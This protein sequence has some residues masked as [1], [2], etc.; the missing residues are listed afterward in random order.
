MN[1]TPVQSIGLP[2]PI[3][4]INREEI[5]VKDPDWHGTLYASNSATRDKW[6][7]AAKMTGTCLGSRY[8][9][10]PVFG[11]DNRCKKHLGPLTMIFVESCE[12]PTAA[13]IQSMLSQMQKASYKNKSSG[14][15]ILS[16][17]TLKG[18]SL[19]ASHKIPSVHHRYCGFVLFG[20]V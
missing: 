12:Q 20:T 11:L 9:Q 6:P 8:C 18:G 1:T 2:G 10:K 5:H 3:V 7:A 14:F 4:P 15:R 16:S 17:A 19:G 13:C